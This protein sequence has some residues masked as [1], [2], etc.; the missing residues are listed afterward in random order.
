MSQTHTRF[1]Q[2]PIV[3][4]SGL[5]SDDQN[6]R[7]ATARELDRA[8]REA[9]FFY[10]TGHQVSR[11]Q[12]RALIEQAK[13]F[14]AAEHDW[15]M[16]YYIGKSAAHRGYVPEGEEVFAAGK[17]DRKEA[18]DTGRELPADDPDV[19]AGTPMLGPNSWP[20]QAGFRE[21]V[22]GYYEAAFELGRALFRG[23]S[24]ALGLPEQHFDQ[25]LRKPPSQL[26]LIHYPLDP[27]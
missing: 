13:R 16:R 6:R 10:V 8:A 7:L 1:Q 15:K 23:F 3:D 12:Q 26:R 24:L 18:F 19:R 14:F 27:S 22:G 20:E 2:L 5:F 11:E 21:A 25:Y 9:G 17:R 4:V